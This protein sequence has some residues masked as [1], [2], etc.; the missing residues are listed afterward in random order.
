M[1]P[2]TFRFR[3]TLAL[4]LI[5]TLLIPLAPT[6]SAVGKPLDPIL[7]ID[8]LTER[9]AVSPYTLGANHRHGYGGFGMY[10]PENGEVYPEFLEM[11]REAGLG[12]VRYPGGTI[13]NLFTWKD[14]VG[15][16]AE[17]R[18]VVLGNSYESVFPYYGLDEHMRYTEAIGAKVIYMVGEAAETPEGAA[19][20]V[21]YLNGIPGE[22]RNGGVD[23]AQKRADNGHPEPYGVT[24][25]E[26]GNEMYIANQQYWL[27]YPSVLGDTDRARRYMQGDTVSIPSSPARRYGTWTDN[28]SDG[29]A[30]QE[31]YT[32][33]NPVVPGSDQVFVD[34]VRWSRVTSLE[35]AGGLDQVYAFDPKTGRITF[36]D[37]MSGAIPAKDAAITVSYRH[38]HAGFTEYYEAMKEADPSIKIFANLPYAFNFVEG[39][40]CDGIVYH[41][42]FTYDKE[43]NDAEELHDAYMEMSDKLNTAIDNKTSELRERTGRQDTIAAF[44]EFGSINNALIYSED[45]SEYGRDEARSLSRALSFA[46]TYMGSSKS[47]ALIHIHQAFTAYSFGG[48]ERLPNADFVYNSMYAPYG[49]GSG[50]FIEGGTALAYKVIGNN[51][52]DSYRNVY[53]EHNP[54]AG[55]NGSYNAL[56]ATVSVDE[57]TGELYLLVVNADPTRDLTSIVNLNGY[58]ISGKARIQTLNASSLASCNTPEH[59]HDIAITETEETFFGSAF[60]YTFPAHSL[61][62]IRLEGRTEEAYQT[63]LTDDFAE[64][65]GALS[66]VCQGTELSRTLPLTRTRMAADGITRISLTVAAEQATEA[67]LR[68]TLNHGNRS[69]ELF[70]L[71]GG[72]VRADGKIRA[73]YEVGHPHAFEIALDNRSGEFILYFDGSYIGSAGRFEPCAGVDSLTLTAEEAQGVFTVDDLCVQNTA[74][75]LHRELLPPA[76]IAI[77]ARIGTVPAFPSK[78]TVRDNLGAEQQLAVIWDLDLIPA[79]AFVTAGQVTVTGRVEGT[80][81]P[82]LATVYVLKEAQTT[83]PKETEPPKETDTQTSAPETSAPS[84][85][86]TDPPTSQ[87]PTEKN[88]LSIPLLVAVAILLLATSAAILFLSRRKNKS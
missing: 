83:P 45:D 42:Y 7:Q 75:E 33:Y 56:S 49:D 37:G 72:F 64:E 78:V 32:Q 70:S 38:T 44:T 59:P 77:T 34:G 18:P 30:N 82:V 4:L 79:D 25:F 41:T 5:L 55:K 69:T 62:A 8:A 27:D 26:I 85:E 80:Q 14:T 46:R 51:R 63:L 87:E 61:V 35:E 76:E 67:G 22:N 15:P 24:Y 3:S 31:F 48:G 57:D 16:V 84:D 58:R 73:V 28:R 68:V 47:E 12:V 71:T 29:S 88:D 52:G 19:D 20:L 66:L 13:A 53:I 2:L 54:T 36:G 81:L 43:L 65:G 9:G 50:R 1:K 6:A 86:A 40:K 39:V 21:E 60:S 17:R 23:W 74:A 10:D 11:T